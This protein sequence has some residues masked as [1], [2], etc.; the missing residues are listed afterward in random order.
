MLNSS[1]NLRARAWAEVRVDRLRQNAL[2]A[3][4]A[5][6][7]DA[8]LV[9]MVKAE[10]YGLGMLEVVRALQHLPGPTGPWAFGVAAVSEGV[11]IRAA[12]WP[13]RIL[14][15][16][17][18]PPQDYRAAADAALTLCV[19]EIAALERLAGAAVAA[20]KQLSF[21]LEIDTGMGR[22]GFPWREASRWGPRVVEI[23]GE[24]LMW[25]GTYTHFHSADEPDL[26]STDEQWEHFQNALA[27]LPR[28]DPQPLV[29]VANSAAIFRRKGFGCNLARPGIYLYGGTAGPGVEPAPVVSVRARLVLVRDVPPGASAGYG[30]TY[31]AR[32]AERWGTLSIG[33]GDGIRRSLAAG[34]G[35]VIVRGV[36]APII[37]RVSMDMITV[38][39]SGIP[40]ARVGDVATLIGEAD[41]EHIALDEVAT[42]C[43]TISY[44]ILTGLTT[45]L[46]RVYTE[47]EPEVEESDYK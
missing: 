15:F 45:R 14:V 32:K 7:P 20:G 43:G 42:R 21:H 30:A 33:Y 24:R 29:H 40:A 35:E 5:I 8:G 41:G 27:Q 4:S 18:A 23:A 22:A 3:Q 34:G 25:E 47:G 31:T 36:R 46:P 13:G 9:P 10:A 6:G 2:A 11:R 19:S 17:P 12:G 38:D 16:S 44:E 26:R 1:T 37:G 28:I 39:L